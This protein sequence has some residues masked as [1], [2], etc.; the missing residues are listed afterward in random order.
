MNSQFDKLETTIN[1]IASLVVFQQDEDDGDDEEESKS[2]KA[3]LASV[4]TSKYLLYGILKNAKKSKKGRMKSI[5]WEEAQ[6]DDVKIWDP[7]ITPNIYLLQRIGVCGSEREIVNSS[8][9]D[10]SCTEL[11][12]HATVMVLGSNA[13]AL[14]DTEKTADV[15]PF[16]PEY[17]ALPSMK[18]IDG[19]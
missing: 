10:Q 5:H 3:T 7:G 19:A 13:V 16:S 9:E 1:T 6:L 11:D 8:D 2:V 12:L 14:N 17:D 4:K 15:Q 18:I